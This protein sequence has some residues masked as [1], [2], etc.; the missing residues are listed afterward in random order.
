[1]N[2]AKKKDT[3]IDKLYH[4]LKIAENESI[5]L[6][7]SNINLRK[8]IETFR[9]ILERAERQKGIFPTQE[10]KKRKLNF[11][12][13]TFDHDGDLSTNFS[14]TTVSS[15]SSQPSPT[16]MPSVSSG[17]ISGLGD[18]RVE[19][20][21]DCILIINDADRSIDFSGYRLKS[22]FVDQKRRYRVFT[23]PDRKTLGPYQTL[24]VWTA[25]EYLPSAD[26]L[27]WLKSANAWDANNYKISLLNDQNRVLFTSRSHVSRESQENGVNHAPGEDV[28]LSQTLQ[29]ISQSF[30]TSVTNLF[31]G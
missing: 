6:S 30:S 27:I 4:Q 29:Q 10:S 17:N 23:F 21:N 20:S 12:N 24:R 18:I 11:E 19:V 14:T 22:F 25:R 26:D 2:V 3:E 8:E 13:S 1:V 28:P 9:E 7:T 5:N 15:T 31:R 16:L